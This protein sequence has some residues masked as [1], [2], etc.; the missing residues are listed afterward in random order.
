DLRLNFLDKKFGDVSDRHDRL[1]S[2]E[3]AVKPTRHEKLDFEMGYSLT[4]QE[5]TDR[6][7]AY[8]LR[9]DSR[10][11]SNSFYLEMIDAGPDYHGAYHDFKHRQAAYQFRMGPRWRGH[12]SRQRS[13]S[14]FRWTSSDRSEYWRGA[15]QVGVDYNPRSDGLN[16]SLEGRRAFDDNP[17]PDWQSASEEASLRL[18][19]GLK[20]SSFLLNLYLEGSQ[21][22][23]SW[24]SS[25]QDIWRFS[26][27]AY[28][29]LGREHTVFLQLQLSDPEDR[30]GGLLGGGNSLTGT[31]SWQ[32]ADALTIATRVSLNH[33]GSDRN[34]Q[35]HHFDLTAKWRLLQDLTLD[36]RIRH[37]ERAMENKETSLLLA[38]NRPWSM[39]TGRKTDIGTVTGRVVD[40]ELPGHPGVPGAILRF[41]EMAVVCDDDG[42]FILANIPSGSYLINIDRHS[43]G[44]GRITVEGMPLLKQ[45]HGGTVT[46]LEI[47]ITQAATL[48][49]KVAT[50][51]RVQGSTP[52][53]S[54][55][56]V[57]LSA[58]RRDGLY[59]QGSGEVGLAFLSG[60]ATDRPAE[61]SLR[62]EELVETY[63]LPGI[64]VEISNGEKQLRKITD[65]QGN[66]L[67]SNLLPG[68]WTVKVVTTDLPSHHDLELQSKEVVL[69]PG[70]DSTLT[71]RVLP[72]LR[73][74][75]VLESKALS[76]R[77]SSLTTTP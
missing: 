15:E 72:R 4:E 76:D 59:L 62:D 10:R 14:Y 29:R 32:S 11:A 55:M 1:L 46:D 65:T 18:G 25:G 43:I 13:N 5:E 19:L 3:Y 50:F 34:P 37:S 49:G 61:P 66:F 24:S 26:T 64:I 63:V 36:F 16:Y 39:P 48:H 20:R 68:R 17:N 74:I 71:I 45:V 33:F 51:A 40:M 58:A 54:G 21:Q 27:F 30:G 77:V 22:K 60:A 44:L 57:V 67:F 8:R 9:F 52:G 38:V 6:N 23:G 35:G 53:E 12:L 47:G 31:Y 73:R 69:S 70:M 75:R 2:V 28:S 42:Q 56:D 41:N 7:R